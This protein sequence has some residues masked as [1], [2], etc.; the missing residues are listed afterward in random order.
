MMKRFFLHC[1]ERESAKKRVSSCVQVV[2]LEAETLSVLARHRAHSGPVLA[3]A[4]SAPGWRGEEDFLG[5]GGGGG[6]GGLPTSSFLVVTGSVRGSLRV[7]RWRGNQTAANNN[8]EDE[9][10]MESFSMLAS[11]PCHK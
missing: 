11:V 7:W 4:L 8:L 2:L 9:D 5:G 10:D 3:L 6:G 1:P